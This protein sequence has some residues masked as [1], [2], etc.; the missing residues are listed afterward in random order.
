MG[1][2][3]CLIQRNAILKYQT[4]PTDASNQAVFDDQMR[5][6]YVAVAQDIADDAPSQAQSV[7]TILAK[8]AFTQDDRTTL[9]TVIESLYP[10][11]WNVW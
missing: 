4:V 8:T 5:R 1:G 7:C 3:P 11:S 9:L 6:L 2:I 10:A